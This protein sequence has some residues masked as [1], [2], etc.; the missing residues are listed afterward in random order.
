LSLGIFSFIKTPL[1]QGETRQSSFFF[2]L[3]HVDS[4]GEAL[5]DAL[6]GGYGKTIYMPGTMRYVAMLAGLPPSVLFSSRV[7]DRFSWT[8][9]GAPEWMMRGVREGTQSL[10]VNFKG[11]QTV[12]EKTGRLSE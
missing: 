1:F 5:V 6:Y 10:G 8:Q 11:R 2:P 3:L 7:A 4:V 9:R 12:N